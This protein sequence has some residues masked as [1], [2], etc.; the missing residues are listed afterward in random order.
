MD[1]HA[2]KNTFLNILI[3]RTIGGSLWNISITFI[4]KTDPTDLEIKK[5]IIGYKRLKPGALEFKCYWKQ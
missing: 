3:V 4:D 1:S 2:L 5:K